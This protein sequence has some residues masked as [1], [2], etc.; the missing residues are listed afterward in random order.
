MRLDGVGGWGR[1]FALVAALLLSACA[2]TVRQGMAERAD[3]EVFPDPAGAAPLEAVADTDVLA[4][5]EPMRTLLAQ[6]IPAQAGKSER[7]RALQRLFSDRQRLPLRYDR[8]RTRT[9]AE[10][11]AA[12]GADCV[13]FSNLVVAM[14]RHV[15]LEAYYQ[16][17]TVPSNWERSGDLA[18]LKRHI[19]VIVAAD[20]REGQVYDFFTD[21]RAGGTSTVISDARARAQYFNN[22]GMEYF[23]AGDQ[24]TALR[25][26]VRAVLIDPGLAFVWSNIGTVYSDTGQYAAAERFFRRAL[27]LEPD[28]PPVLVNL[29]ELYR[30]QG[31][32]A[33]AEVYDRRVEA[34]R[35]RNPYYR[36][37]LALEAYDA[38]RYQPALEH[39]QRA[40]EIK[41]DASFYELLARV[42]TRLGRFESARQSCQRALA[43]AGAADCERGEAAAAPPE[44]GA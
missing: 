4:L 44:F 26:L 25:Y 7:L 8:S 5:S 16:D 9:A 31:R 18:V 37:E 12:G 22:R 20:G 21:G 32:L 33:E 43:L 24:R 35:L 23:R 1:V 27:A 28:Y 13:S 36:Y 42:Y 41:A 30:K 29:A 17:V 40:L 3:R 10:T 34:Y 2:A 6:Q 39:L 38:G 11:F 19:N 15:G 14:A